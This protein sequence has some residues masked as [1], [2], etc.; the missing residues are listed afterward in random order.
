[1]DSSVK[2]LQDHITSLLAPV[3]T[4]FNLSLTA[5]GD[6]VGI[7]KSESAGE[8][9]LSDAWGNKLEPSPIT[10]TGESG[11]WKLLAGTIKATVEATGGG[12]GGQRGKAVVV[13]G[14]TNGNTGMVI[15]ATLHPSRHALTVLQ[16]RGSTGLLQNIFSDTRTRGITIHSMERI[17]STKVS[18][19]R[20]RS[21]PPHNLNLQTSIYIHSRSRRGDYKR[22]QVLHKVNLQ[23][24][25]N[26][27]ARLIQRLFG[28]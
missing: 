9:L 12:Q 23:H 19:V 13:P 25:R 14:L 22:N 20:G 18:S 7:P 24:G 5:F 16:I 27:I 15:C 1:M 17:L 10:P 3:V 2:E 21:L 8:V 28:G 11:P 26:D 4:S 6:S